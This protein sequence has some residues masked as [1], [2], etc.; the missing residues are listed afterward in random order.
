MCK[1]MSCAFSW[2]TSSG[3]NEYSLSGA[4]LFVWLSE[5]CSAGLSFRVF[6]LSARRSTLCL[7][8][9]WLMKLGKSLP[10]SFAEAHGGRYWFPSFASQYSIACALSS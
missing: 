6:W 3:L 1:R 8:M 10:S 2:C 7:P 4:E 9:F 5:R